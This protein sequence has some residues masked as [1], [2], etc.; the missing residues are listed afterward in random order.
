MSARACKN[1]WLKHG[2]HAG[3]LLRNSYE[4]KAVVLEFFR[5]GLA[6]GERCIYIAADNESVDDW[7]FEFQNHGIDV[8]QEQL[9]G[10]L[11]VVGRDDWR[12]LGDFGSINQARKALAFIER[13]LGDSNGL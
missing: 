4:Q 13:S 9:R 11:R 2:D 8:S 6:R 5:K 12:D 7:L 3:H 1:L 10:G